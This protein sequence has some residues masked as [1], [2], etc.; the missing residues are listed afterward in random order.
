MTSSMV[1]NHDN[2]KLGSFVEVVGYT[3]KWVLNGSMDSPA[4]QLALKHHYQNNPHHPGLI[5]IKSVLFVTDVSQ[6]KVS[7]PNKF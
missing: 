3:E 7:F 4:W 5:V 6:D 1:E 2:S